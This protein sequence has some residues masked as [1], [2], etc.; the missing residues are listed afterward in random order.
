M[1]SHTVCPWSLLQFVLQLTSEIGQGFLDIRYI[2]RFRNPKWF[3][4]F[5]SFAAFT[6]G[7]VCR[8]AFS[9]FIGLLSIFSKKKVI[10]Y[11]WPWELMRAIM[12]RYC[13]H[14]FVYCPLT[15]VFVVHLT[16]VADPDMKVFVGSVSDFDKGQIRIWNR[17]EYLFQ[18]ESKIELVVFVVNLSRVA[19]RGVLV[20]FGC[21]FEN[22]LIQIELFLS[23]VVVMYLSRVADPDPW[24]YVGSTL[25][26][27]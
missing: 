16:R 9:S 27:Y 2:F 7:T 15:C 3:L 10:L 12:Y 23:Y 19:D 25:T 4:V 24:L 26:S 14:W 11:N 13:N 22:L 17:S 18:M 21:I 8:G 1:K 5:L 20:G 6:Q